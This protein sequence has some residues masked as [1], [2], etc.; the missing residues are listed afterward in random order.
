MQGTSTTGQATTRQPL[1]SNAA[2]AVYRRVE[3]ATRCNATATRSHAPMLPC[4]HAP[5]GRRRRSAPQEQRITLRLRRARDT[6]RGSSSNARCM[7]SGFVRVQLVVSSADTLLHSTCAASYEQ[8]GAPSSNTAAIAK[9]IDRP[10]LGLAHR[11]PACSATC[12]APKSRQIDR[13][14]PPHIS[15]GAHL[16]IEI[17]SGLRSTCPALPRPAET[18]LTARSQQHSDKLYV[19]GDPSTLLAVVEAP[20]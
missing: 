19:Q 3:D 10:W 20:K 5:M 17:A 4:S 11:Q 16:G 9:V 12:P 13:L 8:A 2:N 14:Q 18:H 15:H 1:A 6:P 7:Q